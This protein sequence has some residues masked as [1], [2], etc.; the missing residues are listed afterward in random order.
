MIHFLTDSGGSGRIYM[1]VIFLS[2]ISHTASPSEHL[3]DVQCIEERVIERFIRDHRH[4]SNA[5]G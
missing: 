2:H 5:R 4:P 3:V 1:N